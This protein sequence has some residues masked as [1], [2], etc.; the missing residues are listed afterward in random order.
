MKMK[1][2]QGRPCKK[3]FNVELIWNGVLYVVEEGDE[4]LNEET[5]RNLFPCFVRIIYS[6]NEAQWKNCKHFSAGF[7]GLQEF[8][9]FS[10]HQVG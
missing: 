2:T 4:E 9:Q 6:Y 3:T 5:H 1:N 7:V 8:S 10:K